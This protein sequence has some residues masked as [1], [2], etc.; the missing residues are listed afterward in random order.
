MRQGSGYVLRVDPDTIDALRLERLVQQGATAVGRRRAAAAG[1]RFRAAV[2]AGARRRRSPTSSTAGSPAMPRRGCDELVLA[3]HEGLVDSELAIGR[4][5]DVLATLLELVAAHPLRERFRAQLII[6]LY[7]CGRQADALQAYRDAREHLL[8]ELGLDPG[9]GAAGA[10]SGPCSP[11][12]RP[13]PRRSP[14]A[15]PLRRA[16]RRCRSP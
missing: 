5:A 4:H 9:P 11:R 15:S 13:S 7:R 1:D 6:A 3:A 10:S 2:D 14:L 16:G 12:I 8:D